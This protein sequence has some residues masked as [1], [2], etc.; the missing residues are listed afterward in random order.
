MA[1]LAMGMVMA[2]SVVVIVSVTGGRPGISDRSLEGEAE[3]TVSA[4]VRMNV[5]PPAMS[6][7]CRGC[8]SPADYGSSDPRRR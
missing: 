7:K 1:M 8:H 5:R 6:M 2:G 4:R 3:V